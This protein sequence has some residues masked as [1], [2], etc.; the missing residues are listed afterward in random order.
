MAGWFASTRPK[1]HITVPMSQLANDYSQA[2]QQTHVRADL[3]FAQSIVET[4]FFSFPAGGQLTP[5]RQQL[6]RHR[7]L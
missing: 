3:A 4:G 5:A 7:R 6:R 2:G 1:P